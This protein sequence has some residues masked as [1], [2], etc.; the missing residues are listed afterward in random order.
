MPVLSLH[1]VKK[2]TFLIGLMI[3]FL[4][5]QLLFLS[6]QKMVALHM[7]LL[8][9]KLLIVLIVLIHSRVLE[10]TVRFAELC[11]IWGRLDKLEIRHFIRV[12]LLMFF[13]SINLA[14]LLISSLANLA[15]TFHN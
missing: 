4:Q 6:V 11:K 12:P 10:L 2:G 3:S 14:K 9:L 8:I 13:D 7:C 15:E 1:N 5:N